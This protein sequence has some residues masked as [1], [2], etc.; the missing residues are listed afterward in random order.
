MTKTEVNIDDFVEI[1]Q[2]VA[3]STIFSME[4]AINLVA[5]DKAWC[6]YRT[7]AQIA[8]QLEQMSPGAGASVF[9]REIISAAAEAYDSKLDDFLTEEKEAENAISK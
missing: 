6:A 2:N 4:E 5:L 7:V 1:L 3:Q 9:T 8:G